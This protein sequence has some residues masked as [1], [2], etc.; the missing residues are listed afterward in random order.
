MKKLNFPLSLAAML[1]MLI[2]ISSFAAEAPQIETLAEQVTSVA[3]QEQ[4]DS[5][6]PEQSCGGKLKLTQSVLD[7]EI[8]PP[9]M[10]LA[11]TGH[12]ECNDYCYGQAQLCLSGCAPGDTACEN[13][14]AHAE[15]CCNCACGAIPQ[16]LCNF[17]GC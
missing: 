7:L 17:H 14:C 6:S 2:A 1:M 13:A 4:V 8:K 3:A 12:A 11:S 16:A 10:T 15:I 5:K 9:A